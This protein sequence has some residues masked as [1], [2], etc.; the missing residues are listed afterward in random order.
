MRVLFISSEPYAPEFI[1]IYEETY[2]VPISIPAGQSYDATNILLSLLER[3]GNNR[4]LI[5]Y[6]KSFSEYEGISGRIYIDEEGNT[7]MQTA[8]YA[9][10][11][12]SITYKQPIRWDGR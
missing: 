7:K 1:Q 12:G 8:I 4:E 5:A 10:E 9:L 2:N 3:T 6:M 11:N